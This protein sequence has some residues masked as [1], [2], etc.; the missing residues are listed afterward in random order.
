MDLLLSMAEEATALDTRRQSSFVQKGMQPQ[1]P[2][3]FGILGRVL[4]TCLATQGECKTAVSTPHMLSRR[5][6]VTFCTDDHTH[7]THAVMLCSAWS[8]VCSILLSIVLTDARPHGMC[9]RV[10]CIFWYAC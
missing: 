9:D 3:V 2:A 7:L 6:K 5:F 1:A 10:V 4:E 8:I